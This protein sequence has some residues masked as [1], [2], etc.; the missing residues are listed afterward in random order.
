LLLVLIALPIVAAAQAAAEAGLAAGRSATMAAPARNAGKSMAG[1]WGSL[2]GALKAGQSTADSSKTPS[3]PAP[4]SGPAAKDAKKPSAP[5]PVYDDPNK[6]QAGLTYEELLKRFGPPS[7]EI[8]VEAGKKSLGY[9][10][11]DGSIQLEVEGGK[12]TS[13]DKTKPQQS[14]VI[15]IQ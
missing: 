15:V 10:A 5:A 2:D 14:S 1:A 4:R 9:T 12:V 3:A 6:I 8:T 11:K 7:M 13:V